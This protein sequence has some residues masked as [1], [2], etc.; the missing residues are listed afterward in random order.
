MIGPVPFSNGI[1][2]H[3]GQLVPALK[4]DTVFSVVLTTGH[5]GGSGEYAYASFLM[6]S[7]T[8]HMLVAVAKL[9]TH[10]EIP[11]SV[12]QLKGKVGAVFWHSGSHAVRFLTS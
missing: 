2:R 8:E 12:C 9:L 4:P 3:Q 1:G 11:V 10:V 5:S 6:S 7:E